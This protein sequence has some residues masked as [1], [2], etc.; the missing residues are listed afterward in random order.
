MCKTVFKERC[1][2]VDSFFGLKSPKSWHGQT[3]RCALAEGLVIAP[4]ASSCDIIDKAEVFPRFIF[5][6]LTK[7][8][9]ISESLEHRS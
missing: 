9:F 1:E 3:G 8:L 2:D 7:R 4:E 5:H 6:F